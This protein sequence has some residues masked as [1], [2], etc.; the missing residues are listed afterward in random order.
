[1]EF[2]KRCKNFTEKEKL[3][4]LK[5]VKQY[6]DII[7]NKKTDSVTVKAKKRAWADLTNK[8]N[9]VS[10]TG[11]RNEKQ[12][13]ALYDN[14]KKIA[15]KNT[16]NDK[17]SQFKIDIIKIFLVISEMDNLLNSLKY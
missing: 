2:R 13:H 12:L 14:L 16:S 4:L 1:M 3:L 17:V 7:D 9:A 8:F 6:V 11:W 15:K 10:E 5:V